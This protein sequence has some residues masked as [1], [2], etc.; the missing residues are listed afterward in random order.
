[1]QIR[2]SEPAP[3]PPPQADPRKLEQLSERLRVLADA[4]HEFAGLTTN[5]NELLRAVARR[6]VGSVCDGCAILLVSADRAWVDPVAVDGTDPE[7]AD[8]FRKIAG[9][10]RI[11]MGESMTGRV[12]LSGE[13]V[14]LNIPSIEML[15]P[16]FRPDIFQIVEQSRL[17][18]LLVLPLVARGTVLGVL[19]LARVGATGATFGEE[20][21]Q[22]ARDLAD[23][24]ALAIDNAR[25]R[26]ELECRVLERTI[27]LEAA[28]QELEAFSFSV[29]HDLS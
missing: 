11:R 4:S 6:L 13:P 7:L 19:N 26:T 14:F 16:M 1:M 2:T 10:Q 23:R 3:G 9:E 24:A 22:L 29:S 15:R 12:A 5:L 25:L 17:S 18:A 8:A 20:D 28:N 27:E 21:H